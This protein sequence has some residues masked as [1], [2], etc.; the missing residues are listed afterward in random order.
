MSS[1]KR[2]SRPLG[3]G[4]LQLD[5]TLEAPEENLALDEAL[6]I[7]YEATCLRENSPK[8]EV[9]R[10]WESPTYFVTLGVAGKLHEEVHV[11]ACR[12]EGVPV[13]RRVSG[14]GTVL[15]G[16]GCLNFALV[17]ALEPH[18]GLHDVTRSY[19][20]ILSSIASS[21]EGG[22][23]GAV[24]HRGTSDLTLGDLKI[25]GNAQK[26]SRRALLHHGTILHSFDLAHI[27]RFL[28]EPGKQPEYR[29]SRRHEDFVRNID[30]PAGEIKSRIARA[31]NAAPAPSPLELPD[32]SKLIAE[33]YSNRAWTERF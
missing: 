26:R 2:E 19:A 23:V 8:S 1:R 11:E 30:L 24:G 21:L 33:K 9:L 17:L 6:L 22:E 5:L 29:Q 28:R 4:L 32:L 25:S 27:P 16:P 3:S 31:W 7:E 12:S 18:P 15:Q 10:F 13:L 20:T 14:G